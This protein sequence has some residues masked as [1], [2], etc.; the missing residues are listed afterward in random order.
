MAFDTGAG[1][2]GGGGVYVNHSRKVNSVVYK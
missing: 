1:G 2:G